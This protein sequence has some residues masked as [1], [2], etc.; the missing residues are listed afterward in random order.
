MS[1]SGLQIAFQEASLPSIRDLL[2]S[3]EVAEVQ[4]RRLKSYKR[5]SAPT[6]LPSALRG[7]FRVSLSAALAPSGEAE[8]SHPSFVFVAPSFRA[9]A[10]KRGPFGFAL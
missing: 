3:S 9:D 8:A 6:A 1:D 10:L 4:L 5:S 7:R 2:S